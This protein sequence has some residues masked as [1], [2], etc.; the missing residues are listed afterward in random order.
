MKSSKKYN[1]GNDMGHKISLRKG[2]MCGID[3]KK[4][5]ASGGVTR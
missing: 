1:Q 3:K 4:K 2:L 5:D